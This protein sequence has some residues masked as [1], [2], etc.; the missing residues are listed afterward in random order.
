MSTATIFNSLGQTVIPGALARAFPDTLT[1]KRVNQSQGVDGGMVDGTATDYKTGVPCAY[2][3]IDIRKSRLVVGDRIVSL[4][5]YK[6][7]LPTH[8]TGTRINLD[9]KTD[10]LLVAARGN[11]PVKAF[12][13]EHI[14]D[15]LGVVFECF[16]TKEN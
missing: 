11:E 16:C 4:G 5:N 9:P 1:V 2:E 15:D 13:I 6:V 14:R 8:Q 12:K 7:T 10:S 3:P